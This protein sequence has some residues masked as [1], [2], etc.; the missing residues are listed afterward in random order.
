MR[1]CCF[2]CFFICCYVFAKK[3]TKSFGAGTLYYKE[4][5]KETEA[6]SGSDKVA[7][8]RIVVSI[9]TCSVQDE[10]CVCLFY[11][12]G[13][14][15]L[16]LQPRS[17]NESNCHMIISFL[18]KIHFRSTSNPPTSCGLPR[19]RF[20]PHKFTHAKTCTSVDRIELDLIVI[21]SQLKR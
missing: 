19:S 16:F 12:P 1:R 15:R 11:T 21:R 7:K 10:Q 2:D 9:N 17:S 3:R 13:T 18:V 4:S 20:D 6:A 8:V 14:T 5:R